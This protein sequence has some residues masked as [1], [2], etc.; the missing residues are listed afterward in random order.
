MVR[1][2]Y[3]HG[4]LGP[5]YMYVAVPEGAA[6][7]DVLQDGEEAEVVSEIKTAASLRNTLQ[8]SAPQCNTLQ[9]TDMA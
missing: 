3:G 1:V 9:H 2:A 5:K 6:V 4:A 8:H 7:A